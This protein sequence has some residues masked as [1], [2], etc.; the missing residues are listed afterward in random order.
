MGSNTHTHQR[1]QLTIVTNI[2]EREFVATAILCY[3]GE[4]HRYAVHLQESPYTDTIIVVVVVFT[5]KT[6]LTSIQ[7]LLFLTQGKETIFLGHNLTQNN[8]QK[9]IKSNSQKVPTLEK[10]YVIGS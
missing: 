4:T 8:V 9:K 10:Q 5:L 3:R 1:T 7:Y 6:V 2:I